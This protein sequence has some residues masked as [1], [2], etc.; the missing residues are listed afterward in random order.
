MNSIER[1]DLGYRQIWLSAMRHYYHQIP[2]DPKSADKLLAKPDNMKA[3]IYAV[4][5]MA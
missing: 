4:Y 2:P 5:E 1:F 3:D